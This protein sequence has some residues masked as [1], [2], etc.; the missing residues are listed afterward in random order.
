MSQIFK[1]EF[2]NH[3]N[4]LFVLITVLFSTTI[5]CYIMYM[6]LQYIKCFLHAAPPH[7]YYLIATMKPCVDAIL[8]SLDLVVYSALPRWIYLICIC[9]SQIKFDL[10]F[11]LERDNVCVFGSI[12]TLYLYHQCDLAWDL[13]PPIYASIYY[14]QLTYFILIIYKSHHVNNW[15]FHVTDLQKSWKISSARFVY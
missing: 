12:S 5:C 9:K 11:A 2:F 1:W 6:I 7:I 13:W 14:T 15:V 3:Y 4:I 10:L 8:N